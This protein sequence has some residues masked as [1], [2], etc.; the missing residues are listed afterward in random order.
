MEKPAVFFR[1]VVEHLI[2]KGPLVMATVISRTGSGPREAGTSMLVFPDGTTAGTIGGGILEAG[3]VAKAAEV[4][5]SGE[6]VCTTLHLADSQASQAGMICGGTVELLIDYIGKQGDRKREVLGGVLKE[7]SAR[8]PVIL[9]ASIRTKGGHSRVGLGYIDEK[10]LTEGSLDLSGIGAV[11][12]KQ[13][14]NHPCLVEIENDIRYFLQP[15]HLPESA[16]IFGAGHIGEALAPLCRFLGFETVIIDDRASFA[17]R[18]RFPDADEIRRIESYRD[19]LQ[20]LKIDEGSFIVIVT[21]GHLH[22]KTVLAQVLKTDAGYI[23]MIGSRKKRDI[24]YKALKESGFSS[25]DLERVHCPIGLDIG[26]ETPAEI[27]VSIAAEMLAVRS[28]RFT[29]PCRKA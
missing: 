22:D 18:D 3:A 9:V 13:S 2:E 17:N 6:P 7:I 20:N 16:F 25:A 29:G 15:I 26:A 14:M 4:Y 28:G 21:R 1:S 19:C 11:L 8:R 27:A 5:K 10:G 12:E 23:G 24:T